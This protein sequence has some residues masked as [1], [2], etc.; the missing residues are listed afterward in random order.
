MGAVSSAAVLNKHCQVCDFQARC[1]ADAANRE[2]LSLNRCHDR[3]GTCKI[4]RERHHDD[5]PTFVW[6]PPATAKAGKIDPIACPSGG[7]ARSQAQSCRYKKGANST[8]SEPL[9]SA[10]KAPRC[11][12]M[13]KACQTVIF[14]TSLGFAT[15]IRAEQ[16]NSHFG[17]IG[18]ED[19][20]AI[21]KTVY[22]PSKKS[23]IHGLFIMALTKAAF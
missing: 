18:P 14:I 5:N 23:T 11:S 19:Q 15:N 10:A 4:H 1:R 20:S 3:E 8:L 21:G 16:L 22:A 2:D 6:L 7:Q 9:S 13:S 12:S 17:R